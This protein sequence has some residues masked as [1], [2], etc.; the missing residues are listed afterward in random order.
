MIPSL[1]RPEVESQAAL[2]GLQTPARMGALGVRLCEGEQ[3]ALTGLA[4]L[5][6]VAAP[7]GPLAHHRAP[8]LQLPRPRGCAS[9]STHPQ[10]AIHSQRPFAAWS[11]VS[12]ADPGLVPRPS[13]IFQSNRSEVVA[14]RSHSASAGMVARTTL[15][16]DSRLQ[17][18]RRAAPGFG[19]KGV[20]LALRRDG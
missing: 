16:Y 12:C 20:G 8:D 15:S 19:A 11:T 13:S 7:V 14:Q 18:A 4:L 5:I 1:A 6:S 17:S 10:E 2:Q 9:P 3:K